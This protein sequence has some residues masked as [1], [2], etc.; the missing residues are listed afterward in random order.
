MDKQPQSV[1]PAALGCCHVVKGHLGVEYST[2][3]RP[4]LHRVPEAIALLANPSTLLT[5]T[6]AELSLQKV[7]FIQTEGL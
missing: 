5:K 7:A 1:K 2:A 6:G 4:V 3:G